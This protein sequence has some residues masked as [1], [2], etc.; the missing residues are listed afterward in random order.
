MSAITAKQIQTKF[1]INPLVSQILYDRRINT[2]NKLDLYLNGNIN[3]LHEPVLIPHIKE[4]SKIIKANAYFGNI[5]IFCD[6]DVDGITSSV[7]MWHTLQKLGDNVDVEILNSN[8]FRDGYGL[9][10]KAVDIMADYKTDLIITLDCGITNYEEIEYAQSLGMDV[11][12]IDHHKAEKPPNC[13]YV[14]LKVDQ[15]H[16]PYW[17]KEGNA[18]CCDKEKIDIKW[19]VVIGGGPFEFKYSIYKISKNS[20]DC[21][22]GWHFRQYTCSYG[23]GDWDAP[24]NRNNADT[25]IQHQMGI[26]YLV[27]ID[28]VWTEQTTN[29]GGV[30]DRWAPF[31]PWSCK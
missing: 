11:A 14:D 13:P 2:S 18:C 16:Y 4:L 8:R 24:V 22:G 9:S 21:F 10:K 5:T 23:L 15:G 27:C 17:E 25:N 29:H 12:V 28:N 30:C 7:I 26:Y 6:Y 31:L 19:K 1:N 20:S 3:D